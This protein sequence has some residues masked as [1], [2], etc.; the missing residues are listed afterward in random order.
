[1]KIKNKSVITEV[2]EYKI[3]IKKPSFIGMNHS[4]KMLKISLN[5]SKMKILVFIL[6]ME[7]S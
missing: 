4:Y 3:N 5:N 7:T 2:V 6:V 1:M